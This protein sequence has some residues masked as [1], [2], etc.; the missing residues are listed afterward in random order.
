MTYRHILNLIAG[1]VVWLFGLVV[2]ASI[3][4]SYE[5]KNAGAAWL[6]FVLPAIIWTLAMLELTDRNNYGN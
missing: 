5:F 1:V 6:T 3:I 2:W 4:L